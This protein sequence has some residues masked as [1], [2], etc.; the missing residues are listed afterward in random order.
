MRGFMLILKPGFELDLRA[1]D[2]PPALEDL[3][4]GVGDYF[5]AV[6]S[7][8]TISYGGTV[9]NCIAFCN[10]HGKLDHLPINEGAT[11]AWE[12][13]LQRSVMSSA[14][15]AACRSGDRFVGDREFMASL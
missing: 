8:D 5:Q 4:A 1:F 7:F 9:L 10:E 13:A 11:I 15:R 3:Q 12:G 6:P 14:T 2:R